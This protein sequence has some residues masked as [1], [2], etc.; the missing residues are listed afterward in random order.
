MCLLLTCVEVESLEALVVGEV[1]T[2]G[3]V[4]WGLNQTSLHLGQLGVRFV[5]HDSHAQDPVEL[6]SVFQQPQTGVVGLEPNHHV[7][8]GE[9]TNIDDVIR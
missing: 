1:T 2:C 4:D 5:H 8:R 3:E 9:Y 6:H 7:A